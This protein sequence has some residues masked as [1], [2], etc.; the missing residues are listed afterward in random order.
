MLKTAFAVLKLQQS[1]LIQ[2]LVTRHT[3]PVDYPPLPLKL[4]TFKEALAISGQPKGPMKQKQMA[5]GKKKTL[6]C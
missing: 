3:K 4:T 6:P 5:E 2:I 1:S